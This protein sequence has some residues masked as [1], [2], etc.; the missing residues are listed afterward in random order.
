MPIEDLLILALATWRLASLLA[1]EDGPF[2][3][4]KRMRHLAGVKWDASS[5][6]Y[7]S[8]ELAKGLICVWCNSVWI[9][10]LLALAYV[11]Q[12]DITRWYCLPLALSTAAVLVEQVVKA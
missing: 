11:W 7:G 8:N 1:A 4:L 6:P 12:P 9:G 5:Q 2:H 10:L 3:I